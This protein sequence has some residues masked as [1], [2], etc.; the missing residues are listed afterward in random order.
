M[1]RLARRVKRAWMQ[2]GFTVVEMLVASVVLL[3]GLIALSQ[4][5]ASSVSRVLDSDIRSVMHQVAAKEME[6]IR[7]LPYEDVGVVNG[8]VPGVLVASEVR[9][10][11]GV[12]LKIARSVVY[13]TDPSYTGPY[14]ANYRR[15][16]VTVSAV[17]ASEQELPGIEPVVLTTY[18]AGG[19]AGGSILVKVQDSQGK[20]VEGAYFTIVNTVKGV[21]LNSPDLVTD[22]V[23]S[24][25]V[26]GLIVDS[27]GNYVVTAGKFGYSTDIATGFA[28]M[29]AGLQEVVLTIDKVSSMRI[30]VVNQVT[31]LEVAGISVAVSGPG[32]Y[33]ATIVSSTG[34]VVLS[35]L[36]FSTDSDPYI[37]SVAAGQGY[38]PQESSV[39]LPP[40]ITTE[41]VVLTI[42]PLSATTTTIAATTTTVPSA[43]TTVVGTGSL[44]VTVLDSHGH[45]LQNNRVASV[46]LGA[47]LKSN[48]QNVVLFEY[49]RF[50]SYE[51]TVSAA[52]YETNVQ[53]VIITGANSITVLLHTD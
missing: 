3:V 31:G 43:T 21:N 52:G 15:V 2:Q 1:L 48:S 35:G 9:N 32:E 19:A 4:L 42:V 18:V 24:M 22:D 20:P 49:L 10:V 44:R 51:L 50:T 16:A 17:D 23:G 29:E 26:P 11:D 41:E 33:S 46:Q 28:V 30:R 40:D 7:G 5:F 14:Y 13:Q 25:L 45:K 12:P 34:G 53:T 27:G 38:V 36:R 39:V 8:P 37:L 47:Q 6:T